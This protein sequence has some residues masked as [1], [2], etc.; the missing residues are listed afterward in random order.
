VELERERGRGGRGGRG[1][2][3]RREGEKEG[4]RRWKREGA[5]LSSTTK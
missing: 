4:G 1:G 3:G 5:H 2:I